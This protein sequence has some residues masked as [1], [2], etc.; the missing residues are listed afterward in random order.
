MVHGENGV[1][2]T[3]Q[4]DAP[5]GSWPDAE[6]EVLTALDCLSAAIGAY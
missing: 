2:M 1:H 4:E 3:R 5:V 6:M